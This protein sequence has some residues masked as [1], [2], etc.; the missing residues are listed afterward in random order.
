M[1]EDDVFSES[2]DGFLS[3][4]LNDGMYW[5]YLMGLFLFLVIIFSSSMTMEHIRLNSNAM[6]IRGVG[7]AAL[8]DAE[9]LH[10]DSMRL[11]QRN[12]TIELDDY[13][14]EMGRVH[15]GFRK[16]YEETFLQ[17]I[18]EQQLIRNWVSEIDSVEVNKVTDW[19]S[20]RLDTNVSD[21]I[22]DKEHA[23]VRITVNYTFQM[24]N[25]FMG[26]I[27]PKEKTLVHSSVTW[28]DNLRMMDY[29]TEY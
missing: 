5:W 21:T 6:V 12:Y 4:V 17:K 25:W 15:T 22:L 7:A 8:K 19:S 1:G 26:Y 3:N 2:P 27:L 18:A 23:T 24:K 20:G 16:A 11:L 28:V 29:E 10:V 13:V 14:D 9:I